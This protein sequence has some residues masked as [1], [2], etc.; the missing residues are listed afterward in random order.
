M[1]MNILIA[2]AI[3]PAAVALLRAEPDF[4][5]IVSN[6]REYRAHLGEAEAVL[7]RS[8]VKMDKE[9]FAIAPRLRVVG[10]AGVGVD[11]VDCGEATARGVVVM[12]TPG[13][14]AIAVAEH[15]LAFML[16]LAR[17]VPGASASTKAGKWEKK[18]FLGSEMSGKTLGIVGF[19]NVGREVAQ[20]AKPFGMEIVAHDPYVSSDAAKDAGVEL[21]SLDELYA[22]ADYISL[23]LALTPE[24]RA[25]IHAASIA[26]MK[27]GVRIVNCARGELIDGRALDDALASGKVAGA[28]LDVFETEPPTASPLL[29]RENVVATPHIGGST[30]EAQEKVGL[31]I[32]RQVRDFLK[33]GVVL[34]AVNMPSVSAEQH[35]KLAPF[36]ALAERLGSFAA[37]TAQGRPVRLKITYSGDFAE[38]DSKLIRN[39]A[40]SGVLNRFL[41]QKANLINAAQVARERAFG[42][43]E[44]RR[45]RTH[46]SDSIALSLKTEEG[47]RAVEG[48]VFPD[49]SPRLLSIDGIYVETRLG[50]HL[51]YVTNEDVPGVIGRVGTILGDNGINIADF[52]LGRGKAPQDGSAANAVAVVLTDQRPP[53]AVLEQLY[54]TRA[55]TFAKAI[56]L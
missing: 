2:D 56:E 45:G 37:Q 52:S 31:R 36:L 1:P 35:G 48:T 22:R 9:A 23:H 21:L 46:F 24:T 51:V 7:I 25:L 38:T 4:R 47:S 15:T 27:T 11:N 17:S 29:E 18:K 34:S 13:G 12:N 40:L 55:V 30:A 28:A 8:A 39:A 19:G 6:A 16:S 41:S 33:D 42:V 49:G 44:V 54:A 5:V 53:A 10:R 3:A 26:K 14:N 32:A 50:G 43:S 20:R